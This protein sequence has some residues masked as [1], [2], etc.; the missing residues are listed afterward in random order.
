MECSGIN[1]REM[2]LEWYFSVDDGRT[3]PVWLGAVC[4]YFERE[5]KVKKKEKEL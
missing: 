5:L 2:H 1:S 3:Y 4:L